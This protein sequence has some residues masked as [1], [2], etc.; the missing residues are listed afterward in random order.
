MSNV[1]S[2]N[3]AF[4]FPIGV[5]DLVAFTHGGS[6]A[7]LEFGKIIRFNEQTMIIERKRG[8]PVR[9][10][11]N[12]VIK[13]S[14]IPEKVHL[15]DAVGNIL[16]ISDKIAFNNKGINSSIEIGTIIELTNNDVII[17]RKRGRPVRKAGKQIIKVTQEQMTM[18][19]FSM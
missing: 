16:N 18:R 13:I 4:G 15:S 12:Q 9:K 1:S 10:N 19:S 14:N 17:K 5:E 8:K 3:D 6:T 11:S 2:M 7:S